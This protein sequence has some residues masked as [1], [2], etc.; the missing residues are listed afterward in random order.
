MYFA[1]RVQAGRM[2]AAQMLPKYR[3]ENC[4]IIV[5]NDGGAVV[6]SQIAIQLHCV[7]TMLQSAEINLPREPDA[8]AGITAEGVLSYNHQ[9]SDGEIDEMVGEYRSFIEQ[10]KLEQM[11]ELNHL[12]TGKG[13]MDKRLL[14]GHTVIL[15]SD[16]LKTG[17]QLDLAYEFL[18]PINYEKLVI[19]VPFASVP[20]V[21]RMHVMADDIYC[22]NVLAEYMETDHYYDEN[23]IPSHKTILETIEQLVMQWK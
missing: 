7:L 9:Y 8:I 20:A 17:F 13:P 1:N 11:H 18:K 21:D 23:D 19:A 12:Y 2:L 16:G 22:L 5:L 14:K 6:G 3:Y 15:V 10:Q 4:A